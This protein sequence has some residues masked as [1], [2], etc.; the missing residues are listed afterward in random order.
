MSKISVGNQIFGGYIKFYPKFFV[1]GGCRR[2]VY[3][4]AGFKQSLG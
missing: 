4:E 3:S 2:Y 1:Q